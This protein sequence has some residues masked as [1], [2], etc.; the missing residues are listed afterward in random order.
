[1]T[2]ASRTT[3]SPEQPLHW[4]HDPGEVDA[5]LDELAGRMTCVFDAYDDTGNDTITLPTTVDFN[6]E[7]VNSD[8][9]IFSLASGEVT[10]SEDGTY[11]VSATVSVGISGTEGAYQS[12]I[13]IAVNGAEVVGSR[14]YGGSE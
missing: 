7:R 2:D 12:Y 6:N 1:M 14:C 8:T 9:S 5:A 10:V 13:Y 4:E 11:M 3:Y